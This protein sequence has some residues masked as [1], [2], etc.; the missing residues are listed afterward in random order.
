MDFFRQLDGVIEER[1]MLTHPFYA[2]WSEGKVTLEM[3]REYAKQYYL[4]VLSFPTFV[5]AAHSRC[6]DLEVRKTLLENLLEEEYGQNNHLELWLR[7]AEALG[8][9]REEVCA[10]KYLSTTRESVRIL[11]ELAGREN[12]V[13]G[14]AS[15]YAY[16]AQIP[17]VAKAKI[18]GL[19]QF[20]GIR[21]AG[22]LSFFTV[23]QT[24]DEIHSRVM[25]EALKRFCQ[26]EAQRQAALDAA[27]E[28]A[29]ACNL[30][31]DGVYEIYCRDL[32]ALA[33]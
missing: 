24:A 2:A 11:R 29:D 20:Y 14:L 5:S 26:S 28:A 9:S 27:R 12:V 21:S 25:L 19:Q 8:L 22:G 10:A 17:E 15:L 1:K 18:E 13:E 23:H 32:Y 31:L 7:F 4:Q 33:A 3:L 16:E 30:L 6:D